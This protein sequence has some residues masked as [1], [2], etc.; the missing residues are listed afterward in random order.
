VRHEDLLRQAENA[1]R[2]AD[3]ATDD[4]LKQTLSKAAEDYRARAKR[5]ASPPPEGG[6]PDVRLV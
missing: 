2:R 6:G 5:E 4:E 3:Q 1:D